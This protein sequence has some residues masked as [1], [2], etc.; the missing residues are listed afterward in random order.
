MSKLEKRGG[1]SV[2][3]RRNIN[4]F[5]KCMIMIRLAIS[6]WDYNAFILPNHPKPHFSKR[7]KK[8][9]TPFHGKREIEKFNK[10]V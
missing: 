7:Y 5:G 1:S 3:K 10:A 9:Y 2:W 6:K 8:L 4:I